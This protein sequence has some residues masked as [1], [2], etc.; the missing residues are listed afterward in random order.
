[1]LDRWPE[2]PKLDHDGK[3]IALLYEKQS[4]EFPTVVLESLATWLWRQSTKKIPSSFSKVRYVKC[5]ILHQNK[6][7]KKSLSTRRGSYFQIP[8]C[9]SLLDASKDAIRITSVVT[10]FQYRRI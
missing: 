2:L 7:S 9:P 1:M 5:I 10:S 4:N 6:Q 3:R 8:Q